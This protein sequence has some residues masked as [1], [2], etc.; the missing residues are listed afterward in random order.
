MAKLKLDQTLRRAKT[1]ARNGETD[2]A[3]ALYQ[4]IL[5]VFPKNARAQQ[6]LAG[7][8]GPVPAQDAALHPP[9]SETSVLLALFKAGRNE[10]L[11]TQTDTLLARYPNS[12]FLWNLIGAGYRRLG[13]MAEA[14]TAFLKAADNNP[15]AADIYINLGMTQI[16]L[17]KFAEAVATYQTLVRLKPDY[18][19]AYN[20]MGLALRELGRPDAALDALRQAI[21]IK[22]D[23]AEAHNSIG[24]VFYDRGDNDA[25]L[26][27]Y[28]QAL[29]LQ[30]DYAAAHYNMGNALKQKTRMAEAVTAYEKALA[31]TPTHVDALNNM[32]NAL[33]SLK[34]FPEALSTL[35][36]AHALQP[37][38][39]VIRNNMGNVWL[40]QNDFGKAQEIYRHALTLNPDYA[41]AHNNLGVTLHE[42]ER[43]D[44]A[45]VALRKA[46]SLKPSF[47]EAYSNLGNCLAAQKM[48]DKAIDAYKQAIALRPDME[49]TQCAMF[50][51]MQHACDW[52][53]WADIQA[54]VPQLGVSTKAV[55]PFSMLS[56]EDHPGRQQQRSRSWATAQASHVTRPAPPR[57]PMRRDRLRI[58]YFSADIHEHPC[59]AL[60]MG[61]LRCHDRSQ[62]EIC[63]FSYGH[64]KTGAQRARAKEL[65]DQFHDVAGMSDSALIRFAQDQEL[66]VAI[67][68]MGH[69]RDSRLGLFRNRLAPVHLSYVGFPGTT[70]ANFIDYLVGDPTVIPPEHRQAYSERV[71]YMP[72]T[73]LPNDNTL[74]ISD[75]PTTRADFNLPED[76]FVLCCFNNNYKIS[77]REFDIWMRVMHQAE[78]SVLWMLKSNTFSEANLRKEAAARGI[79][80]ARIIVGDKVPHPEHMARHRHADIFIDTFNYN[81]HTTAFEALWAGLPVVTK[82]GQQFSARVAA[83]M[84][85]SIGLPELITDSDA[86]YEALILDLATSPAKVQAL[87]D[88]LAIQRNAQPFFDTESYTRAFENGLRQVHARARDGMA[89]QDIWCT[90]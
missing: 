82:I 8:A 7:L 58:G 80:P 13:Q 27:A 75:K 23:H 22:P 18:V 44:D 41:E 84:L 57:A 55:S 83:S 35:E 81:A 61:M 33:T 62:F 64:N 59:L 36:R 78:N 70:G 43:F 65:V 38:N 46:I 34:R 6:G 39:A 53:A 11:L 45:L 74:A 4:S 79:D 26:E 88:K 48:L 24:L 87:K 54:L 14:E 5:D 37:Q 73:Y 25:A 49:E 17:E 89:P 67:D 40:E 19:A 85:T 1:H 51:Q 63:I 68:L 77:P 30:P 32:G 86:A 60:L 31:I 66:D 9:K 76:A 21:S 12:F 2:Q 16:E 28:K 52:S 42:Q 3:R 15:E 71:F 69:T 20:N 90:A 29:A 10:D 72:H 50:H 47:A 56:M